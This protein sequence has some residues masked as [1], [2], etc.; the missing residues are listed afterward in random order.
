MLLPS[1][2]FLLRR[3]VPPLSAALVL[4]AWAV[5]SA[6]PAG[7]YRLT[8]VNG[9]RVPMVWDQVELP[10]GGA[11]QFTWLAGHAVA[12]REGSL[13][14]VL[15]SAITGPGAP[16]RPVSDTVRGAWSRDSRGH[17][18]IRFDDGRRARWSNA[19]GYRSLTIRAS[20]TDLDGERRPVTLV[21]VRE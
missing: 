15:S 1:I 2:S 9:A 11:L 18:E 16:G 17:V 20:R 5:G 21:M 8:T 4:G 12:T 7:T 10:A 14:L 13:T 3:I 6:D 19:D